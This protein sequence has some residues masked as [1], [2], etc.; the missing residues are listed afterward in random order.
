MGSMEDTKRKRA[1]PP[2]S[3]YPRRLPVYDTEA[4]VALLQE[5]ARRRGV[6]ATALVRQLVREEAARLGLAEPNGGTHPS[7]PAA[8]VRDPEIG[9][10]APILEGT[11]IAVHDV[12]SYARVYGRDPERIRAEALPDLSLQ[13]IHTALDWYEAHSAEID[14]ILR[15]HQEY[16]ESLLVTTAR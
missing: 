6:S 9:G 7:P 5:L 3:H 2:G 4:G 15:Q 11:R 12:I 1:R 8:I 13:Q 10:G 14:S 16:Y